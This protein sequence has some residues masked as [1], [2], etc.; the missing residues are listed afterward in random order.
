MPDFRSDIRHWPTAAALAAHLAQ[1]DPAICG[2]ARGLTYH[3]TIVPTAAQWRGYSTMQGLETFYASKGWSAGPHLFIAPDGIWQLTPLNV[4]GIHAGRCNADHWGIEVC[5]NYDAAPWPQS[6]AELALGAGAA[7]LRWRGL[8]VNET[9]V[10]GHRE[11]LNNKS[12]PGRAIQLPAVRAAL[13][14]RLTSSTASLTRDAALLSAPRCTQAQALAY[15]TQRAT[16]E[17]TRA[18]LALSILPAYWSTCATVGIDPCLAVAQMILETGNLTSWWAQRP[19]R[20][21]AGIGV[22]SVTSAIRPIGGSWAQDGPIWR[23]GVSFADWANGSVPAHVGRLLAYAT[24]P[25]DR[26][27]AQRDLVRR[28]MTARPLANALHGAAPTLAGL[29]GRWAVPGV[30]YGLTI[31]QIAEDVRHA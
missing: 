27:P 13:A 8:P 23:E 3:H 12:C 21:P 15:L 2:W 20:N 4:P 14:Q 22:T 29:D 26:T 25:A 1:Y 31:V 17:Y 11:C 6:L 19:R 30:G 5:G 16:G 18:D 7:L 24:A 10:T 28:A 9:T